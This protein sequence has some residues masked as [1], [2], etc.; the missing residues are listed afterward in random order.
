MFQKKRLESVAEHIYGTCIL[1][2]AIDSEFKVDIDLN[3]VLKML[4]LHEL[5]E[6]IIGDIT[7]YDNVSDN[8]KIEQG[9]NAIKTILKDLIKSE[10]YE[11]LID[12]FNSHISKES[13]FAF[14]CDKLEADLQSKIYDEKG[15]TDIY[16]EKNKVLLETE[17]NK[18]ALENGAKNLSDLFIEYDLNN[19]NELFKELC[20]YIKDNNIC[21]GGN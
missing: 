18:K 17:W 21:E 10:E 8:E 5:E 20:K 16:D 2:I 4:V 7:P 6:V 9:K 15:F 1:A 12:E 3:K 11:L 13:L 19:Y 14:Y